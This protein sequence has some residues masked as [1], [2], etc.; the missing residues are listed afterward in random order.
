MKIG[1]QDISGVVG[2]TYYIKSIAV[3][4][5]KKKDKSD[6]SKLE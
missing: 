4:I 6:G 5:L 3:T 1:V 2:S